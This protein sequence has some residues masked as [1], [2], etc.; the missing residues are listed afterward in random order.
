MG[1]VWYCG[2]CLI[3]WFVVFCDYTWLS[4]VYGWHVFECLCNVTHAFR[5]SATNAQAKHKHKQTTQQT[6]KSTLHSQSTWG[7][8]QPSNNTNAQVTHKLSTYKDVQVKL[9]QAACVAWDAGC[10]LHYKSDCITKQCQWVQSDTQVSTRHGAQNTITAIQVCILSAVTH[11][12]PKPGPCHWSM[13][14]CIQA[15]NAMNP[16]CA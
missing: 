15:R 16:N 6:R 2:L 4:G 10:I 9:L 12:Q 3:Y 7:I 13:H 14:I 11:S 8:T 1:H 5:V